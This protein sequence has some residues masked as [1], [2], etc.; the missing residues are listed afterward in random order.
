M[1]RGAN[2]NKIR[3]GLRLAVVLLLTFAPTLASAAT[4]A[5]SVHK[6]GTSQTVTADTDVKLTWST[7]GFDSNNNFAADRFTPTIAGKF[8][9]VLSAHCAQAGACMPSIYKNGALVARSQNTNFNI[10]QTPQATA[11]VEM[12]GSTD[13]VE[14]F[15]NSAGTVINGTADRTYFSGM[16]LDGGSGGGSS[17]AGVAAWVNFDGTNGTIQSGSGVT[18]VVR[19]GVGDYTLNFNSL[20]DSNFAWSGSGNYPSAADYSFRGFWEVSRSATTLR[21]R[22]QAVNGAGQGAEDPTR[23]SIAIFHGAVSGGGAGSAKAW[24]NFNGYAPATIRSSHNVSSVTRNSAGNYTIDFTTALANANYAATCT[25][26][27][28]AI[29]AALCYEANTGNN[30]SNASTSAI[31]IQTTTN[32]GVASDRASINVMVFGN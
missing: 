20:G 27:G 28:D 11:I 9:I 29:T 1:S 31:T 2:L 32:G 10:G 17:G 30:R 15:I 7:E 16:Q 8:L 26:S 12:N 23:A 5:F 6:N 3:S 14:A 4:P 21:V 18:N 19:N 25:G 13:Y 24:V 22:F